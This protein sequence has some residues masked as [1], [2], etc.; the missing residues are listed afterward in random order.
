MAKEEKKYKI[1]FDRKACIGAAACA[2]VCPEFWE[3]KDDGKAH[4]IGSKSLDNNDKQELVIKEK[5][6]TKAKKSALACNKEAA[7]DCPANVIHIFDEDTGE[8]L[9]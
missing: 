2:A 4:L 1:V 7:E 9:I 5:Q 8:K 3:M 6:L